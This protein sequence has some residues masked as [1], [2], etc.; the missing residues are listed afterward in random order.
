MESNKEQTTDNS[1]NSNLSEFEINNLVQTTYKKIAE[2]HNGNPTTLSLKY[3]SMEIIED[4]AGEI[5]KHFGLN[6]TPGIQMDEN[7]KKIFETVKQKMN[8][9]SVNKS[10]D[11]MTEEELF[12]AIQRKKLES[13]IKP[14]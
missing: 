12:V 1:E 7:T 5:F 3:L 10:V 13:K 4:V 2:W 11:D 14:K 9:D 6:Y 8:P